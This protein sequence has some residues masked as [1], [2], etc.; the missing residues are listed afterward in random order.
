MLP[1][2]VIKV[3]SPFFFAH[4]LLLFVIP[5]IA[6]LLRAAMKKGVP[7]LGWNFREAVESP[8]AR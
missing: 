4:T 1:S 8:D 6:H 3:T 2:L 7:K 5:P